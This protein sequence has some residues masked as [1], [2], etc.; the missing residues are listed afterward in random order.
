MRG[1]KRFTCF[2]TLI[3]NSCL[4]FG[5]G[6]KSM[7]AADVTTVQEAAQFCWVWREKGAVLGGGYWCWDKLHYSSQAVMM[8]T[9]SR[10]L[11]TSRAER[12]GVVRGAHEC[13]MR[14]VWG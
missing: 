12:N 10:M 2:S 5:V 4:L 6:L 8:F 1:I 13:I 7:F 11:P 3:K 14:A 9:S